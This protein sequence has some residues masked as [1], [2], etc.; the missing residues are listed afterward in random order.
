MPPTSAPETFHRDRSPCAVV[1]GVD[2]S[3]A[4]LR[5]VR[6]SAIEAAGRHLPLH[7]VFGIDP[8]S[9]AG[10]SPRALGHELEVRFAESALAEADK[11]AHAVDAE[12]EVLASVLFT[13]P[14]TAMTSVGP[15]AM[16]CL[17]SNG[18]RSPHPG[19]RASTATE[20]LL[21]A[22]CAVT[23]VRGPAP[24]YGWAVA[25]VA[26]GPRLFDVLDLAVREAVLRGLPLRLLTSWGLGTATSDLATRELD[27]RLR[28]HV[29]RWRAR[30]LHLDVVIV[31][32]PSVEEFL[33]RN[34]PRIALFIAPGRLA[35]DVGTVIHPSA[36]SAIRLLDCPVLMDASSSG[37]CA[38]P[39]V[40]VN[41]AVTS[42]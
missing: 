33:C 39:A 12:L 26:P 37:S 40:D 22:Q 1:V 35:Q 31:S 41:L 30:Y 23:V 6:W 2:G 25:P 11:Q 14:A 4:A 42:P 18:A 15:A 36:E 8:M 29:D 20:V 10:I 27:R 21:T 5:A 7:L 24:D 3:P 38:A 9:R 16:I 19:H 34:A 32:A 28:H 13:S 17:G